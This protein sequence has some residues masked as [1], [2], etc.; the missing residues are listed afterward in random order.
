LY[1]RSQN[2][3]LANMRGGLLL[4]L[5]SSTTAI[6]SSGCEKLVTAKVSRFTVLKILCK[7]KLDSKSLPTTGM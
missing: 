7:N 4:L 1:L 2:R 5:A 6:S 3:K